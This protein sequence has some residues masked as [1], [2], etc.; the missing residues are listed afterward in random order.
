MRPRAQSSMFI[1]HT[2]WCSYARL[3]SLFISL[4]SI[5]GL[6]TLGSHSLNDENLNKFYAP[7]HECLW[8]PRIYLY[9]LGGLPFTILPGHLLL[10]GKK[11]ASGYTFRLC[12][13]HYCFWLR[14]SLTFCQSFPAFIMASSR[15]SPGRSQRLLTSLFILRDN[16]FSSLSSSLNILLPYR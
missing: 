2:Y 10:P 8:I 1:I 6:L 15:A 7:G 4:L 3:K 16:A 11:K 5:T 9:S 14:L 12:S 13:Y